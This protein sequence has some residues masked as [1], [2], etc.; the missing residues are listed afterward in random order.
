MPPNSP[1]LD[2]LRR[3]LDAI[4]DRLQDLLI[5]RAELIAMVAAS[6][7]NDNRPAFQPAREAAI[8]R[9]LAERHHGAFPLPTLVR[10]WRE[11]LAATVRLQAPFAVAVY[12]PTEAQGF[13][14]LARDHFG[15]NTAM[16]ALG[17]IGQVVRA[18]TEGNA[19]IGV[20]PMPRE[21][22]PDPWW[23]HL[24]STDANAPRAV[25]RLP[26]GA[27]GNSR[28]DGA[29]ALAIGRFA[30]QPTG[31][32]RTLLASE[33]GAPISRARIFGSLSGLGL[34]CTF[35][36]SFEHAAGAVNLIEIEGFVPIADPRLDR[37]CEQ[38]GPALHRLLPFGGYAVP[39][40]AVKL[41]PRPAAP[42]SGLA[43]VDAAKG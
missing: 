16:S 6:K 31:H 42:V 34:A 25:A 7:I 14:D 35:F 19:A 22:D 5:E 21:E 18:V 23:R 8:V 39:L 41:G 2:E 15:S 10:M 20:L 17:S 33:T 4:D 30:Q 36:A 32:D 24:L 28:T 40:P 26:F 9:R 13:W 27:R 38:L 37:F 12:A 3:Q 43:A 29:D 1:D 11:M